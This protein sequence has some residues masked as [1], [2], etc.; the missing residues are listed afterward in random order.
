[1]TNK[2]ASDVAP[3]VFNGW[4]IYAHSVFLDQIE[5]LIEEVETR[6]ARDAR[7][8]QKKGLHEA[9]GRFLQTGNASDPRRSWCADVSARRYPL[10][11][12]KALVSR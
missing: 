8:W 7:T 9:L 1:M 6:K 3:L 5:G 11:P 10:R 2:Y 12:Q 4:S